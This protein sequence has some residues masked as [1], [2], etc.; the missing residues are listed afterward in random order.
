MYMHNNIIILGGNTSNNIKWLKKMT[1]V[2]KNDYNV[3]TISFD[4][5]QDNSMINFK[6][7]SK[8]LINLCKEQEKYIILA[9]S[10]G[11][12]LAALEIEKGNITPSLFIV[13][14]MPLKFANKNNID[15]KRIFNNVKNKCKILIIQQKYD[16][17]G[18]AKE[19]SDMFDGNIL[20]K[21]INGNNH[22]YTN[23][24]AIKNEV[25]FFI[26]SNIS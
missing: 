4:N 16:P 26:K 2:Y 25:D 24:L 20:V 6:K 12:V 19:I 1:D 21:P 9:K 10:A 13:L 18:R 3:L 5:W 22:V 15:I 8:K 14:G 17:Q 23:F 11:A 7:E